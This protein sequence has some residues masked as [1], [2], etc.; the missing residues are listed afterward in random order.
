ML[1]ACIQRTARVKNEKRLWDCP[2]FTGRKAFWLQNEVFLMEKKGEIR[3]RS[4]VP[5]K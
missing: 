5:R 2:L 4:Q 3:G 1:A